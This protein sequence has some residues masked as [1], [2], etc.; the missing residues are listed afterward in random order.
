MLGFRLYDGPDLKFIHGLGRNFF[1]SVPRLTEIQLVV[2]LLQYSQ[3]VVDN[4]QISQHEVSVE[5]FA[6]VHA[7]FVIYLLSVVI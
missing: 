7:L 3:G 5:F 4:L 6:S 2:I 1:M